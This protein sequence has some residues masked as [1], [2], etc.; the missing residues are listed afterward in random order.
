M[1]EPGADR[2]E[3]ARALRFLR[4]ANRRFGGTAATL[5]HLR[6]WSASWARGEEIRLIDI[7]TGSADVPCALADWAR[8]AGFRMR[9]VAVDLHPVTLEEARAHVGAQPDIELVCADA[10]RLLDRFAP[11]DFDYAH[12]GLFLHHLSDVQVL[13]V[14]RIMDRLARRGVIWNDLVRGPAGRLAVRL[15]T[16]GAP[17]MVRHDGRLSVEA[18]FTRAEALDLAR[19]AGLERPSYR[20]HWGYRFTLVSARRHRGAGTTPGGVGETGVRS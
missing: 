17:A 13:T 15:A 6:R 19:R 16:L 10:L 2:A 7:G 14:L 9:V 8:R 18:G 5:A 3:L 11:G 4:R 20:A 12:A 1:D